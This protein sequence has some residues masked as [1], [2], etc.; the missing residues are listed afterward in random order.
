MIKGSLVS[1]GPIIPNDFES[2]F[3]W[4][5]D[6]ETARFNEVYRP[7]DWRGQQ[8]FWANIGKNASMVVFAIRR[9]DSPSIIG[10]VQI[11]NIDAVHRS[12]MIGIKIGDE[13]NRGQGFG[14]EALALAKAYCWNHLNLSRVGLTVFA[15]NERALRIYAAAGFQQEGTLRNAVFI[16]GRWIDVVVM[17]ANHPSRTNP[18]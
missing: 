10:Y 1:L 12:A 8:E 5:N 11:T 16:A 15:T 7:Q 3:R 9:N 4:A 6:A 2:L 17:A 18:L 14:R 13:A